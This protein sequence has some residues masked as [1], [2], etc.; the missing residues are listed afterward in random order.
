MFVDSVTVLTPDTWGKSRAAKHHPEK[1]A[2][3]M[4]YLIM[5]SASSSLNKTNCCQSFAE[6]LFLLFWRLDER[7]HA[8]RHKHPAIN[9]SFVSDV[10]NRSTFCEFRQVQMVENKTTRAAVLQVSLEHLPQICQTRGVLVQP[11]YTI[12]IQWVITVIVWLHI[13]G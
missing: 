7:K 11:G 1:M 3:S 13:Q 9:R 4:I 2:N 12:L 10:I 8:A 6:C 5:G